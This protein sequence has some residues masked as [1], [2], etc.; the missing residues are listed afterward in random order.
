MEKY[1][2]KTGGAENSKIPH[3]PILP[4]LCTNAIPALWRHEA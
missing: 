2:Q 3:H 4:V 1:S